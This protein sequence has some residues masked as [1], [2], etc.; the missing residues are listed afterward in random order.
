MFVATLKSLP[1]MNT[2]TE[3]EGLTDKEIEDLKIATPTFLA[4][5]TLS[6]HI[7]RAPSL[8]DARLIALQTNAIEWA[9]QSA[10]KEG[11]ENSRLRAAGVDLIQSLFEKGVYKNNPALFG[12]SAQFDLFAI[13]REKGT[14]FLEALFER[15]VGFLEAIEK[16]E[17]VMGFG[18]EAVNGSKEV[19]RDY[20]TARLHQVIPCL[21]L[22]DRLV[23]YGKEVQRVKECASLIEE[24]FGSILGS[25]L[26]SL[27]D[28]ITKYELDLEN[29]P[30][31]VK[32][33]SVKSVFY[34][35]LSLA[36]ILRG[37]LLG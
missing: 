25:K 34:R 10:S 32:L 23:T 20:L 8:D 5:A 11:M 2:D 17:E 7:R 6:D 3:P 13:V 37:Y 35:G 24:F 18:N 19:W 27:K 15:G 28:K 29:F 33:N 4:L 16:V 31:V 21:S 12:L 26:T 36:P 1:L 30:K 9:N 22:M 14:L